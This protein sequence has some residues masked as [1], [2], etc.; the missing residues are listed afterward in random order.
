M[1]KY[2][3]IEEYE[4]RIKMNLGLEQS[5]LIVQFDDPIIKL[6]HKFTRATLY[7]KLVYGP[8]W[9]GWDQPPVVEQCEAIDVT[10]IEIHAFQH[11]FKELGHGMT[12]SLVVE[13]LDDRNWNRWVF[14]DA[15]HESIVIVG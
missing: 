4:Q 11:K 6:G 13:G 5:L 7:K 3:P 8:P 14:G 12:A 9:T 1:S 2:L 15:Q 10:V